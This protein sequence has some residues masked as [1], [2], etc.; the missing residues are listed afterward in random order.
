M[1]S[2]CLVAYPWVHL[3]L[4]PPHG[5][6]GRFDV[7]WNK[8]SF[9]RTHHPHTICLYRNVDKDNHRDGGKTPST[10]LVQV[11]LWAHS[12]GKLY[13]NLLN[14]VLIC[15][16]LFVSEA[17]RC[18][19]SGRPSQSAGRPSSASTMRT[20]KTLFSNG[21]WCCT[22]KVRFIDRLV[23]CYLEEERSSGEHNW[24][25][26][27]ADVKQNWFW[28]LFNHGCIFFLLYKYGLLWF[29]VECEK[30]SLRS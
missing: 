15:P 3:G 19:E 13:L 6:Q 30:S 8:V 23:L 7:L 27:V 17:A 24:I 20:A 12:L 29:F 2:R 14:S 9:P 4:S 5:L 22:S 25:A 28:T 26:H 11:A 16:M 18:V 10:P 1:S 21:R